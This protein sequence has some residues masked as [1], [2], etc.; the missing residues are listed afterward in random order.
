MLS[1]ALHS[2]LG[3]VNEQNLVLT[4]LR[5]WYSLPPKKSQS[6]EWLYTVVLF[7]QG[8]VENRLSRSPSKRI[9]AQLSVLVTLK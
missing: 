1:Q 8:N 2:G 4:E 6:Y 5:V 3:T 9:V 7:G